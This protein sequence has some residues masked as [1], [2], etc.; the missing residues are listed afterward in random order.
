M[1]SKP[2]PAAPRATVTL[3]AKTPTAKIAPKTAKVAA[4][5]PKVV[6]PAEPVV[7]SQPVKKPEFLD[8]AVAR[9]GVKRRDAKPAIEAAMAELVDIL[10]RGDE[11]NLPPLGKLKVMK[12][13]ELNRGARALTLKLRTPRTD[14]SDPTI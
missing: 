3:Q 6:T 2:K 8:R 1:A 13:K 4:P 11:L 14:K 9:S 7:A 10:A 5:S 12:T